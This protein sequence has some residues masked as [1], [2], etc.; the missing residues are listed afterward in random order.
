MHFTGSVSTSFCYKV[1][2]ACILYSF[3]HQIFKNR[4]P[5]N[6]SPA[7]EVKFNS[8]LPFDS[9]YSL[10]LTAPVELHLNVTYRVEVSVLDNRGCKGPAENVMFTCKFYTSR[11]LKNI[12]NEWPEILSLKHMKTGTKCM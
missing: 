3:G 11:Q 7:G 2:Y 8:K 12:M 4:L 9:E 1:I 10:L 5:F 6:M